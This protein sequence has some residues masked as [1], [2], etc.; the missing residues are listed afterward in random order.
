MSTFAVHPV[1][2][3]DQAML[4]LSGDVDL[5]AVDHLKREAERCLTSTDRTSLLLD[6]GAVTFI[7]S[8]GMGALVA[9]HHRAQARDKTLEL[10]N[11]PEHVNRLLT[12]SALDSLLTIRN[13]PVPD[14]GRDA[15]PRGHER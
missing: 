11:V 14:T 8:S 4:V 13:A 5:N 12:L 7:D 15:G 2:D 1:L 6:L 3:A 10:C 9:V